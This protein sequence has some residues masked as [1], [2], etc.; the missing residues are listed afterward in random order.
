MIISFVFTTICVVCVVLVLANVMVVSSEEVRSSPLG[1]YKISDVTVSGVSSGGYMAVQMH[2]SYSSIINGTAAFAAGPFYCAEGTIAYAENKCMSNTLGLPDTAKLIALT[3]SD[4]VLG[5]IDPVYHLK[6]DRVYI[7]S[8][9]YDSVISQKVVKSLQSYYSAFIPVNQIVANFDIAAEHC[10]PTLNYGEE[11]QTLSSPYIGKCGFDGAQRIV[12]TMYGPTV[13]PKTTA[14][15]SNLMKFD[16]KSYWTSSLAAL[17][18]FGYIY[19]PT[20]CQNTTNACHLHVAFHGCLQNLE[21][22]GNAYAAN[23][24]LNEWAESNHV[25]VLYPYAKQSDAAPFN[26]NGCW[27]WWGYTNGL[28]GV[29]EGF[30]MRFVRD[31]IKAVS[32]R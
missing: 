27:D 23:I 26:P 14:I 5:Y 8:G 17:G 13:Q 18:D 24:G 10:F 6:D 16:Q 1:P 9:Q 19:V 30:Q 3:Y 7:F 25:V 29:K 15:S 11:C 28:Y 31:L 2:I 12:E 4:E 32:G 20:Y 22:V 21:L